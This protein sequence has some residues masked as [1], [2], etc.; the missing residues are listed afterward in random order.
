MIS[1]K[2]RAVIRERVE[3]YIKSG[4]SCSALEFQFANDA[5]SLLAAVDQITLEIGK[6]L[7]LGNENVQRGYWIAAVRDIAQI[8]VT[9]KDNAREAMAQ[10]EQ[11]EAALA[12]ILAYNSCGDTCAVDM[13]EIAR[14]ALAGGKK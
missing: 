13:Q 4:S 14:E 5:L 8:L 1:E 9:S 2:Q 7:S 6:C 11:A 10:L 3:S 12:Q